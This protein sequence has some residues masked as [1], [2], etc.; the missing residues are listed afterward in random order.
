[1]GSNLANSSHPAG[2]A[3][4]GLAWLR[5]S[6]AGRTWL[7]ALPR[8]V[9]ECVEQW[10]LRVDAPFP[11]AYASLALKASLPEGSDVVLKIQFPDR[12]SEHEAAALA[13]WD[14]DGAVR[15]FAHDSERHALLLERC[16]PGAPLSEVEQD[17][18]LDEMVGLLPR[19]WKPA[20]TLF[21]SLVH[22]AEWWSEYLPKKWERAGRPFERALLDA[23]L[24]ALQG[25]P[26]SQGEQVLL[27][28]DLHAGNVLSAEREPWLVI[29]PKPLAGEREFGIAALVRGGEL[30]HG[31]QFVEH[32]LDRLTSELGLDRDRARNWALAQTLAWAFEDDVVLP[33][34]VECAHW[35]LGA[36]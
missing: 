32:R 35:L 2:E 4:A 18:A 10:S 5:A 17:V 36:R 23:A 34:M 19:L 26:G 12:E 30:G 15:L 28:Q 20:G 24:D 21:R 22:E 3:Q 6:E 1:L 9:D 7:E 13:H 25:L 11:Y 33:E 27:H 14:G 16:K 8:L 29:D 31:R